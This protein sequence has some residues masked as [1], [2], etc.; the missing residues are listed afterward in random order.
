MNT[1]Y[2]TPKYEEPKFTCPHCGALAG[3]K[4]EELFSPKCESVLLE[5]A[6]C[7]ACSDFSIWNI[8]T[9]E[10]G[11]EPS[12]RLIYPEKQT[13]PLPNSDLSDDCKKDY[14]EAREIQFKSPRGAA[15]LL[16][17]C[18]EK[19]CIEKG[20]KEDKLFDKIGGLINKGIPPLAGKSLDVVRIFAND[21][22]HP[23][24][25]RTCDTAEVVDKL[26]SVVNI[27][28]EHLFTQ[29]RL[30]EELHD[31]I[32]VSKLRPSEKRGKP[33]QPK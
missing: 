13:A 20:A 26:F 33:S 29:P 27:I 6:I 9:D 18:I 28:A 24:Q 31:Q 16:R 11:L 14:M 5:R 25:L 21:S 32:P 23:A 3:M 22:V 8:E 1:H 10:Y 15:A 12:G 7:D 4:W 2:L 30:V 19:I 17:L